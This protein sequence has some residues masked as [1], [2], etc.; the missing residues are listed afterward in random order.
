MLSPRPRIADSHAGHPKADAET[1]PW[2]K[3]PLRGKKCRRDGAVDGKHHLIAGVLAPQIDEQIAP[4]LWP[5]AVDGSYT[6]AQL[7]AGGACV[8]VETHKATDC[9]ASP[10]APDIDAACREWRREYK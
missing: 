10:V 9:P 8:I 1:Q 7:Q 2:Q 4:P 5:A 3:N 6:I